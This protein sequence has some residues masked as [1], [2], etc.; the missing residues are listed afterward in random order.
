MSDKVLGQV[1]LRFRSVLGADLHR[2][3]AKEFLGALA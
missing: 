2:Q 3:E 1:A